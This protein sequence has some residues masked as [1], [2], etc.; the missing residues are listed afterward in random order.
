MIIIRLELD[1]FGGL[2][3]YKLDLTDGI[4]VFYGDNGTGKTTLGLFIKTMLYGVSSDRK[5]TDVTQR[6]Q[7]IP[8][9]FQTASGRMTIEIGGRRLEIARTFGKTKKQDRLAMTWLDDGTRLDISNEPGEYFLELNE[10]TFTRTCFLGEMSHTVLPTTD[11]EMTSRLM[12]L[13]I[14][15]HENM[16][17]HKAHKNLTA[18]AKALSNQRGS[19]S[20]DRLCAEKK[21]LEAK[22]HTKDQLLADRDQIELQLERDQV[23]KLELT[24]LIQ[25]L[26]EKSASF[27]QLKEMEDYER[28]MLLLAKKSDLEARIERIKSPIDQ[29]EVAR[30]KNDLEVFVDE[31]AHLEETVSRHNEAA[32]ELAQQEGG[33]TPEYDRL[34]DPANEKVVRTYLSRKEALEAKIG[35]VKDCTLSEKADLSTWSAQLANSDRLVKRINELKYWGPVAGLVLFL[36]LYG[37]SVGSDT[38]II[39]GFMG[40]IFIALGWFFIRKTALKNQI[41]YQQGIKEKIRALLGEQAGAD[42]LLMQAQN[43]EFSLDRALAQWTEEQETLAGEVK[44]LGLQMEDLGDF[45]KEQVQYQSQKDH[46]QQQVSEITK[47]HGLLEEAAAQLDTRRVTLGNDLLPLDLPCDKSS[48][49]PLER[50]LNQL[51]FQTQEIA[52]LDRTMAE[53]TKLSLDRN[54]NPILLE[55]KSHNES[56]VRRELDM[57]RQLH[58]ELDQ[59]NE[60]LANVNIQMVTAKGH[61][62]LLNNHLADKTTLAHRLVETTLQLERAWHRRQVLDLA[63]DNLEESYREIQRDYLPRVSQ[64]VSQTFQALTKGRYERVLLSGDFKMKIPVAGQLSSMDYL[65]RGNQD[66]LWLGLRLSLCAII[67]H[68]EKAPLIFDDSFLHLDEERL[69]NVLNYLSERIDGQIIILTC[70]HRETRLLKE[71]DLL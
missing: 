30:I 53:L 10:E 50:L 38:L 70:H 20:L 54:L 7:I 22:L 36:M 48:L 52:E 25:H 14:T 41:H 55:P 59:A 26:K 23:R 18:E 47:N 57:Q 28:A 66:L 61:L 6:M 40:S 42:F 69:K 58:V 45:L 71:M 19:G 33:F 8:L 11:G 16:D 21:D 17:Y 65:S 39:I 62:D 56:G 35:L 27:D 46:W 63:I 43:P 60:E 32:N 44:K 31:Q 5:K 68:G 24:Q 15:G 2:N 51:E 12:N 29:S 67:V 37:I 49:S 9:S 3:D 34:F 64:E 4:N 1:Q 13:S